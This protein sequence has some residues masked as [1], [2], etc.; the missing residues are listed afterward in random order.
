MQAEAG[1]DLTSIVRRKELERQVGDTVFFWGVGNAPSRS[2]QNLAAMERVVPVIF[3][4]MRSPPK[5]HDAAPSGILIWRSYVDWNGVTHRL[6]DGALVTSRYRGDKLPRHYALMCRS[7]R[8]LDLSNYGSFDPTAYRNLGEDGG[9]IASSQVTALAIKVA[10][11][12]EDAPYRR[13]M[14]AQLV[15]SYWVRLSDPLLISGSARERLVHQLSVE[16]LTA[17]DWLDLVSRLKIGKGLM[18]WN[19]CDLPLLRALY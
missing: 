3:S 12:R 13:D 6:P 19:E 11:E 5:M 14:L 2:T 7:E 10:K 8:P 1:Q 4:I 15:G 17:D 9:H 18:R 16:G